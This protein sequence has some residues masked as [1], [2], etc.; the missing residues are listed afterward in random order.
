VG[1]ISD[2]VCLGP[3]CRTDDG[4]PT[5]P[6]LPIKSTRCPVCGSKRLQRLWNKAPGMIR[7]G[8]R[9]IHHIGDMAAA[10]AQAVRN[11]GRDAALKAEKEGRPTLAVP[12]AQVAHLFPN[13]RVNQQG[14]SRPVSTPIPIEGFQHSVQGRAP[15]AGPGSRRDLQ[16]EKMLPAGARQ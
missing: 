9:Q 15:V 13:L 3:K 8:M 10:D 11:E 14:G 16:S 5:Y 4:A 12:V 2:F 1:P 7:P 6:D